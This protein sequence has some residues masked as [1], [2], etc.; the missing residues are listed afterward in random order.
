M[1]FKGQYLNYDEYLDLGGTLKEVPFN[2]LEYEVRKL[3]DEKTFGRLI[4]INR[5]ELPQEVKLCVFRMVEIKEKYQTLKSQ[6]KAIASESTDG[7]SVTYRKQETS[8]IEI[9]NKELKDIIRSYLINVI[10]NDVPIIY[11]GVK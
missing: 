11:L 6:N 3:I 8:D 9:E 10:I 7:Y 2:L 1:N 5:K 4:G